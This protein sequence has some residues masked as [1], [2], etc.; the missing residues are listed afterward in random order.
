MI[1]KPSWDDAPEWANYR[2]MDSDCH[3]GW[4]EFKPLIEDHWNSDTWEYHV[5][6]GRHQTAW[7]CIDQHESLDKRP[8]L[9][10]PTK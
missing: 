5:R 9:P 10:E 2:A 8:A 7:A 6:L 3:W 1:N 4:Y